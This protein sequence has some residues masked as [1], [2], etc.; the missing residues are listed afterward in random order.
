MIIASWIRANELIN[1]AT[2]SVLLRQTTHDARCRTHANHLD[3]AE[4][5]DRFAAEMYECNASPPCACPTNY[6][7]PPS[8]PLYLQPWKN[9]APDASDA[10]GQRTRLSKVA[11]V[12]HEVSNQ[13]QLS[14]LE[15]NSPRRNIFQAAVNKREGCARDRRWGRQIILPRPFTLFCPT[16]QYPYPGREPRLLCN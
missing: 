12:R 7:P 11:S 16:V 6:I 14:L 1:S 13:P 5:L 9:T 4:Q 8:F 3:P 10:G 2:C 15:P